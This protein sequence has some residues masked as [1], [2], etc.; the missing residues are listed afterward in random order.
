M[1]VHSKGNP[2]LKIMV[3]LKKTICNVKVN[4]LLQSDREFRKMSLM[5]R[6]MVRGLFLIQ[7]VYMLGGGHCGNQGPFGWASR[8]H[9]HTDPLPLPQPALL[10]AAYPASLHLGG[11]HDHHGGALLPAHLPEVRAGVG[12]RALARDVAVDQAGGGDLHL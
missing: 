7:D 12:Q 5:K 4:Q 8:H 2:L 3:A 10:P 1:A 9:D 6:E 11:Q